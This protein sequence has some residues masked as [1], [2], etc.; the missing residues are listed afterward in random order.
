MGIQ[1]PDDFMFSIFEV[2][3][4]IYKGKKRTEYIMLSSGANYLPMTDEWKELCILEIKHDFM[5]N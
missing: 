1:Y 2:C 4:E 3:A 5:I